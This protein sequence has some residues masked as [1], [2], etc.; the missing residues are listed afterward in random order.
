M[1]RL[2]NEDV[3][4][5]DILDEDILGTQSRDCQSGESNGD[6]ECDSHESAESLPPDS[7]PHEID[8]PIEGSFEGSDILDEGILGTQSRDCQSGESNGDVECASHESAESLPPDSLPQEIDAPIEGSFEGS[9]GSESVKRR[10]TSLNRYH[11]R[12]SGDNI[13][14]I[15]PDFEEQIKTWKKEKKVSKTCSKIRDIIDYMHLKINEKIR[16]VDPTSPDLEEQ[17]Q[18]WIA[19]KTIYADNSFLCEITEFIH[20]HIDEKVHRVE[21]EEEWKRQ[22]IYST[23]E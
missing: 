10:R 11:R 1:Q 2:S 22:G 9:D 3:S 12:S 23:A 19:N 5:L 13:R 17:L 18:I 21:L 8:A 7:L 14:F 20:M 4:D 15:G 16:H 6:V